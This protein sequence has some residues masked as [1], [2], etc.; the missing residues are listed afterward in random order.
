MVIARTWKEAEEALG[1]KPTWFV[2]SGSPSGS[3][4]SV[5]TKVYSNS[6]MVLWRDPFTGLIIGFSM[7]K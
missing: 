6:R 1:E 3:N 7:K 2:G 5:V 4:E